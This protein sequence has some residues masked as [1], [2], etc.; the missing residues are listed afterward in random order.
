MM[1]LSVLNILFLALTFLHINATQCASLNSDLRSS[2]TFKSSKYVC[3]E[4]CYG[5]FCAGELFLRHARI[6]HADEYDLQFLTPYKL[7]FPVVEVDI[8]IDAYELCQ[9]CLF[10]I[11]RSSLERHVDSFHVNSARS[12]QESQ[13][14][15]SNLV[16]SNM[17]HDPLGAAPVLREKEYIERFGD[18]VPW[19]DEYCSN[20]EILE[21]EIV[22]QASGS[23]LPNK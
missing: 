8:S 3:C 15:K 14:S 12:F 17:N 22:S 23:V 21:A 13:L 5:C 19:F 11:L 6:F 7:Y 4:I 2:E 9:I 1:R 10:P 16:Q 20:I 18:H